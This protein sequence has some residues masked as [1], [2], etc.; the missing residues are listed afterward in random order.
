VDENSRRWDISPI[1]QGWPYVADEVVV[2]KIVGLDGKEKVQMR[3]P[4]G[5]LQM[6]CAGR[7]DGVRPDGHESY[8]E[9][10]EARRHQNPMDFSLDSNDCTLLRDESAMYYHRYLSLYQLGDYRGVV[11]DTERNLRCLDFLKDHAQDHSDKVSLEQYRPYIV[12]MN[13][14]ARAQHNLLSKLRGKA[15]E[16]AREGIATIEK[17]LREI[18][19]EELIGRSPE[20]QI[21]RTLESEIKSQV[22]EAQ[23]EDLRREMEKA[24]ESEDYEHAAELRDEIRRI[25]DRV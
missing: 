14:R 2:R 22:P 17:F 5:L 13:T 7:P 20:L 9:L 11:R 12:M 21:L 18:G 3:L 16:D 25:E 24:I 19:R 15:L 4:L 10:F 8:L 1:L 23:I 6:E